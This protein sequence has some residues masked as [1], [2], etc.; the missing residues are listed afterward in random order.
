MC[1]FYRELHFRMLTMVNEAL[2]VLFEG[3]Q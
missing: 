1:I 2:D 3:P